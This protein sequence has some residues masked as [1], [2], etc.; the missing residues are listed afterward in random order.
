M[1]IV[2]LQE[3]MER[4][5][6]WV[7]KDHYST[8]CKHPPISDLALGLNFLEIQVHY[9]MNLEPKMLMEKLHMFVYSCAFRVEALLVQEM[10][11]I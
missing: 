8:F 10:E 4:A 2:K 9:D 11:W 1:S 6:E 3:C 7:C 5:M